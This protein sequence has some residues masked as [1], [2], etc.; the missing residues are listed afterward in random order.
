MTSE[1]LVNNNRKKKSIDSKFLSRY[2][3][4]EGNLCLEIFTDF[5]RM[6]MRIKSN[7]PSLHIMC[8]LQQFSSKPFYALSR[9]DSRG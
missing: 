9:G 7:M 6:T 1:W 5:F 8:M 4:I 3:P 2:A